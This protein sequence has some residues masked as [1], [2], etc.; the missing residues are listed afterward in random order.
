MGKGIPLTQ[1]KVALVDD[2]DFGWLNH[3]KW[4]ADKNGRTFYAVRS[5]P[6]E[7][8]K[9]QLLGM[10][11]MIMQTPNG[12]D[13]DH[14]DG[15]GLNNQKSNLR[16]CTHQENLF[17]RRSNLD[18]SSKYKGVSWHKATGKWRAQIK[19]NGGLKYIGCYDREEYAA[20][21]Y[22]NN[23]KELYGEFARTSQITEI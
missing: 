14:I 16:I 13:T 15:D 21:A 5:I 18:V 3:Y 9:H 10:H 11:R 4:C 6:I 2:D 19:V 7:D 23:A 1:G 8:G 22:D 12:M 17:N 20:M